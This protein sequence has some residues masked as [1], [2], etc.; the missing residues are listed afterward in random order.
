M[1]TSLDLAQVL[2][3]GVDALDDVRALYVEHASGL[4]SALRRLT[5]PGADYEDLL[6]EVFIIAVRRR[7]QLRV[8]LSQKA[9]LYNVALKVAATARRSHRVRSFL[10]LAPS[11]PR[12]A[13]A[14]LE[15]LEA[16]HAALARLA[17]KKR[18]VL[19]LFELE[20]FSGPEIA[21]T[22]DVPLKTVWTR[23]HH[24]RKEFEKWV[25]HE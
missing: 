12:A 14:Q 13:D 21:E 24:A 9:W 8:V 1:D 4:A 16:V 7:A 10:G 25:S 3:S 17:P 2:D 18:E 19:V 6:Q 22:L 23:L 20:G 5:W 11:P 15:S